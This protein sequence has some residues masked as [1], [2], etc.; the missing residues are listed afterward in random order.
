MMPASTRALP[1]K[2]VEHQLHGG[3]FA[4]CRAPDRDQE[5]L[6]DDGDLV[7]D[8]EQEEIEAEKDSVNRTDQHEV[9]SE[10]IFRPK[11][12]VPGEEY[13]CDGCDASE[14]DEDQADA[15]GGQVV[16]NAEVRNPCGLRDGDELAG[17]VRCDTGNRD[18]EDQRA[19]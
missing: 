12:D 2:G 6:R 19:S 4:P 17:A 13:A 7:E 1:A 18:G 3:V 8:E 14:Q 11:L 5:I 15:I 9:Q 10:E 16:F